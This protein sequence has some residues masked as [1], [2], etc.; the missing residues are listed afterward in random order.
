MLAAHFYG[1]SDTLKYIFEISNLIFTF[2]FLG[3]ML[4]LHVALGFRRYWLDA[5]NVCVLG[6]NTTA[7]E[8]KV[9]G[10]KQLTQKGAVW[11]RATAGL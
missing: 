8:F 7:L 11:V 3:E 2:I 9:Q 5:F 1:M 4:V 10:T 6:K